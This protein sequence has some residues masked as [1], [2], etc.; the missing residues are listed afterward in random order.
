M[1]RLLIIII[2]G[3]FHNADKVTFFYQFKAFY[4]TILNRYLHGK[5]DKYFLKLALHMMLGKEKYKYLLAY[6]Y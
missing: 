1:L 3:K 2:Q 6:F 4:V 5:S